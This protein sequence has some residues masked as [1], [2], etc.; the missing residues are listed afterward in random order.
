MQEL[1]HRLMHESMIKDEDETEA[2]ACCVLLRCTTISDLEDARGM[3]RMSVNSF[4]IRRRTMI[5]NKAPITT[6]G[7]ANNDRMSIASRAQRKQIDLTNK[8]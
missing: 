8:M 1:M 7:R 4:V 2:H 3:A 6:A 5:A